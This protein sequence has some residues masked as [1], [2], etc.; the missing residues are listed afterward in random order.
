MK[1]YFERSGGFMGRMDSC[2]VDTE[3]LPADEAVSLREMVTAASFF[4]LP[5]PEAKD[6]ALFSF[7]DQFQYKLVVESAQVKYTVETSDSAV[8]DSLRPLLRRLTIMT[9]S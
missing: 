6:G 2:E 1:I 4:E 5:E 3:S 9:R 7:P 8:P